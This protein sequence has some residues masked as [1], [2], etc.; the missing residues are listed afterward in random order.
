MFDKINLKILIAIIYCAMF[1]APSVWAQNNMGIAASVNDSIITK[2]DVDNRVSLA[3]QGSNN[4]LDEAALKR[5]KQQALDALID[6]EIRLQE[7]KRL[8][9]VVAETDIQNGLRNIAQQNNIPLDKF[10]GML[11]RNAGAFDS[12]KRQIKT[13]TA[14]ASVVKQKIRPKINVSESDIDTYLA[15]A[16]KD[17]DAQEYKVNEIFLRVP[18]NATDAD[19][20]K[21][22]ADLT[23]KIKAGADFASIAQQASQGVEAKRGGALGWVREGRLDPALESA[24]KTMALNQISAP[25]RSPQG[26]HIL[27]L[28][29]KRHMMQLAQASQRVSIKQ[30]YFPLPP[31]AP[32]QLLQ[33]AEKEAN[34]WR[35]NATDCVAA[36]GL[37][38]KLRTPQTMSI[39]NA[40]LADL[41]PQIREAVTPL[42]VNG[43][44][45]LMKMPN[46]FLL[47]LKCSEITQPDDAAMRDETAESIGAERL[48]RLQQAY[49]RDLRS[50]AFIDIKK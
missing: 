36:D 30:L 24:L 34:K 38:A 46:G 48:N 28:K 21:V 37:I 42:A 18:Q 17:K 45:P 6:E 3:T 12:L 25:I 7:A 10:V 8:D 13:Q 26:F 39:D 19:T 41:N 11:G 9:I 27:Q 20:Q 40:K 16:A 32:P 35:D 2:T 4:K 33:A 14:W 22:A 29:D 31:N 15:E 1:M 23:E 43:K 5:L 50:A 49:F 47:V 44:T